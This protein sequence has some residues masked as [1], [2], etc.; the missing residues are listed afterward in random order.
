MYQEG[1]MRSSDGHCR[2]FDAKA[3][4]TVFASGLGVVLLKRLDDAVRDG[5][6]ILAVVKG[7]ALNNDGVEKASYTA[8]SIDGQAD[9]I[10]AAQER[11]GVDPSTITYVE[12]H[13]T[14][15]P[16]GDPIEVAALTKAFRREADQNQFCA[17]G[18]VKSNI[19]HLDAAAGIAGL[20]KVVLS[21][22]N[23]QIPPTLHFQ[24]ANPQIN[25]ESSPFYVVD[26]PTPWPRGDQ[27]RRAGLSSFGVG[28]TNAHAVIEEAPESQLSGPSRSKQLIVLS[29]KSET[30]LEQQATN[31]AD[32]LATNGAPTAHSSGGADT[33]FVADVAYTLAVGRTDHPHRR[34]VVAG[35][36]DEVVTSLRDPKAGVTGEAVNSDPLVVF[37]FPG[38]GSQFVDMGLELYRTEPVFTEAIDQCAEILRPLL[39]LDLRHVLYPSGDDRESAD[40]QLKQTGLAQPAIFS[41]SYALAQ[42]WLSWGVKPTTLV[43]HSVGEY[44]AACLAGVFT[45]DDALTVLAHR[46]RLMQGLPSGAMRAVRLSESDVSPFLGDGVTLAAV[47]APSVSVVSGP[48]EAMSRFEGR[49]NDAGH[50]TIVLH[51][52]HAFHSEMMDPI[53]D[54]FAQIVGRVTRN[55]PRLP[56]I[57][58][59]TG[60]WI[61]PGQET[62]SDPDYWVQQLRQPVRFSRAVT[63]LQETPGRVLLEVGPGKSLSTAAQ[64]HRNPEAQ[65]TVVDSLGHPTAQRPALEAMLESLGRLWMADVNLDWNAFYGSQTRR[66][67]PLPTY[68]F[69][70]KRHWVDPPP[71]EN[72]SPVA[73][74]PVGADP[75]APDQAAAVELTRLNGSANGSH[76]ATVA[77]A[78]AMAGNG[79]ADAEPAAAEQLVQQQLQLMRMQLAVW[80]QLGGSSEGDQRDSPELRN[81]L[82]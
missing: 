82:F 51:T 41:V 27:P 58:T 30:A 13:G 28:G 32:H 79:T 39:D 80:Q 8:P 66:R 60:E 43:G 76:P 72:A 23:E 14:A 4:G 5:D 31:L 70:R 47:N 54:E 9:V 49:L 81:K 74:G 38:Q 68:P 62:M 6:N 22:Q 56:I 44:V 19:G 77:A 61:E 7:T 46:G 11:A 69:E 65:Q 64:Q 24:N 29:A 34:I 21:M 17:L 25:F 57:S 26:E 10:T 50:E 71:L 1:G 78:A 20:I 45:L 18:A 52:S 16:L 67:V 53:L 15:T 2:P 40:N 55:A 37:M 12:A 33:H 48:H 59:Y 3:S 35:S 42:T 63:T 36:G 73:P 75:V